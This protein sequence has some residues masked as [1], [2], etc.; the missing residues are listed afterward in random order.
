MRQSAFGGQAYRNCYVVFP[1]R[2]SSEW[3]L[4]IKSSEKFIEE[5]A[6]FNPESLESPPQLSTPTDPAFRS[7]TPSTRLESPV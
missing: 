6:L 2:G 1:L 5:K 3:E 7:V 4:Y